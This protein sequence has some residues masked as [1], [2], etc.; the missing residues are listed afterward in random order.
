[1]R[2]IDLTKFDPAELDTMVELGMLAVCSCLEYIPPALIVGGRCP[3]CGGVP[4]LVKP[5][6][7]LLT[8]TTSIT[9]S[10]REAVVVLRKVLQM[11]QAELGRAV[12]VHRNTIC[13]L[14]AGRNMR[15]SGKVRS[16][17][18]SFAREADRPDLDR[19]LRTGRPREM[20]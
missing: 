14:E 10:V 13:N 12:G 4:H 18:A 8:S 11:T 9:N 15:V 20:G 2:N 3:K 19:V 5:D 6:G 16:L 7:E 17:L 1:M